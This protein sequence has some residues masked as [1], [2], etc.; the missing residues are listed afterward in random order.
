MSACRIEGASPLPK[1]LDYSVT[2]AGGFLANEGS[3]VVVF[4]KAMLYEYHCAVS[5]A[6]AV[7]REIAA[8]V[9][10]RMVAAGSAFR[11]HS[12]CS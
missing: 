10:V 4:V 2:L 5:A 11:Q 1:I 7:E 3:M 9:G 12:P 8:R 6:Y